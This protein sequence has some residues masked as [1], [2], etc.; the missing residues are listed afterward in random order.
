M[1]VG[2]TDNIKKLFK[3]LMIKKNTTFTRQDKIKFIQNG[4]KI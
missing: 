3:K 2:Q 4:N 1:E